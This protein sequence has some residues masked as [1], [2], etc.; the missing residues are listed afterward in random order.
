M[1]LTARFPDGRQT[2]IALGL[3]PMIIG[4]RPESDIPL[5]DPR[6]SGR[7][8]RLTMLSDGRAILEDL[9]STN[10]T[11]VNGQRVGERTF[12]VGGERI[13]IGGVELEYLRFG[14]AAGTPD[15]RKTAIAPPPDVPAPAF[16]AEQPSPPVPPGPGAA[17]AGGPPPHAAAQPAFGPGP[18]RPRS[19]SPSV[20]QRIV[21]QRSVRRANLLAAAAVTVSLVAVALLAGR[22]ILNGPGAT[23]LPTAPSTIV[24]TQVAATARTAADVAAEAGPSTLLVVANVGGKRAESGTGWVLDGAKGLIVTNQH[25]VNGGETFQVGKGAMADAMLLAGAPC[26]DLAVLQIASDRTL[27]TLPLGS[28]G[29]LR[30]GDPVVAIGYPIS[31]SAS[32]D[33][34]VTTGIISVPRTSFGVRPIGSPVYPNVVQTSAPINPGN[35]GGPLLGLDGKVVGVNTAGSPALQN[36]NYAIGVDRVKEITPGLVAGHSLGWTGLG[37][38]AYVT[39]N[40]LGSDQAVQRAYVGAGWPLIPGII[41]DHLV[42]GHPGGFS[43]KLPALLVAVNGKAMDGSLPGYCDALAGLQSASSAS[44]TFYAD[45]S[46]SPVDVVL[47]F[48]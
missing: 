18:I 29:Q 30:A 28:Q 32:D 13:T 43:V 48:R 23:P 9:G 21:L 17:W 19:E 45:G 11:F 47:P 16:R 15:A 38:D 27:R 6:I 10:G 7:H 42:A 2:V 46:G 26:E 37:F 1:Q 40:G 35:S 24:P 44:F 31:A 39:T 3:A 25:V 5:D 36:T 41:V 4:R 34:V 8:A 22:E 20:I 14:A 33:L 12:L